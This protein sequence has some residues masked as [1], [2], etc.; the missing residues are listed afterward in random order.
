[1]TV[2]RLRQFIKNM[3]TLLYYRWAK[4]ILQVCNKS[5]LIIFTDKTQ[6]ELNL[7]RTFGIK[8]TGIARDVPG[9]KQ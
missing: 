6:E 5:S 3:L 1:M 9:M 4:G 2:K 7:R 8:R